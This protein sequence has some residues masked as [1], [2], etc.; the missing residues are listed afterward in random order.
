MDRDA[1]FQMILP[2]RE[3]I[4][5]A[6]KPMTRITRGLGLVLFQNHNLSFTSCF[7]LRQSY[8][9]C[10]QASYSLVSVGRINQRG[11]VVSLANVLLVVR[12]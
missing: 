8:F 12:M 1:I 5:Q 6:L 9:S 11:S 10:I 2:L 7:L 4:T 3:A